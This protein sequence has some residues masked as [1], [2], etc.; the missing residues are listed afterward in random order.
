MCGKSCSKLDKTPPCSCSINA[1][2]LDNVKTYQ[3]PPAWFNDTSEG[4]YIDLPPAT[5]CTWSYDAMY[6]EDVERN[7]GKGQKYDNDKRLENVNLPMP[8]NI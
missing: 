5:V 3:E 6:G 4:I 1:F 2:G 8:I 7:D